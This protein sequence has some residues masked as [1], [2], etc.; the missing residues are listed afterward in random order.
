[1]WYSLTMLPKVNSRLSKKFKGKLLYPSA[2]PVMV[3]WLDAGFS[4]DEKIY[5]TAS[6]DYKAGCPDCIVGFLLG[7]KDDCL[8]LGHSAYVREHQ[9]TSYRHIW[10]IP[11][12]LIIEIKELC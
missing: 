6:E 5:G 4:G 10:N 11:L 7:A 2:K 1:M 8:L 12:S 9:P 3:Y